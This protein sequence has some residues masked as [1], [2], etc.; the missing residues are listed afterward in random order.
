[1]NGR[2][3]R[4]LALATAIAGLWLV[5]DF[6]LARTTHLVVLPAL[7]PFLAV[8]LIISFAVWLRIRLARQAEEERRDHALARKERAEH[9]LFEQGEGSEPFTRGR[10][11]ELYER[12]AVPVL[13][14]ALAILQGVWTWYL[15][16]SLGA[17]TAAPAQRLVVVAVLAG[18][19]FVLFL[20][21][22]YLL[23]LSRAASDRLLR[24]PAV[25]LGVACFASLL[26]MGATVAGEMG[27]PPV[28]RLAAIILATFLGVLAVECL[29]NFVGERYRP[30]R[31]KDLNRAYESRLGGLL[32]DPA[33]WARNV[34]QALDYQ[35]GFQV[36]ETWLFRFLQGAL[37]PLVMFQ[38]A[39]LY[40]LSCLVFLGPDEEGILERFGRPKADGWHLDSGF[41]LKWPWPFEQVRRFPAKRILTTQIGFKHEDHGKGEKVLVWSTPHFEREDHFLVASREPAVTGQADTAAGVN[42]LVCNVTLEYRITNVFQF[43]YSYADAEHAVEK[44]GTRCLTLEAASHGLFD[45]MG[46][47]QIEMARAVKTR[48]QREADQLGLGVEFLFVGLQG[49]HP[50]V[51]VAEAFE[52]VI[53]AYEEREAAVLEARAYTN[54]VLPLADANAAKSTNAAQAYTVRRVELSQA[55]A[56]QFTTRLETF[57]KS[58]D[59]FQRRLY[60]DALSGS[61]V[62]TRKYVIAASPATEVI[63]LNLEEKLQPDL[64]DFGAK[65]EKKPEKES[66]P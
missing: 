39:T 27:Y 17:V 36:S 23:G 13:A 41:H 55:E 4:T 21:S 6:A 10:N 33:T 2:S 12:F 14:P 65:P 59:V 19:A 64:F 37:L 35:F 20:F 3:E 26:A 46:A 24:A 8:T 52:S 50:P 32:T 42:L 57:R 47:G 43:A 45:V 22:R 15:F 31:G 25:A 11:A 44:L 9:A 63:Q 30:R 1:M 61:L 34:A 7:L 28:E 56:T 51:A 62:N 48:M 60:L 49:V 54:S 16:K 38:L 66:K 58:P 18:Q 29:L 5:A 53:G 40:L